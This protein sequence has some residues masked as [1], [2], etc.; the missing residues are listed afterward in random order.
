MNRDLLQGPTQNIPSF[1]TDIR[2]RASAVTKPRLQPGYPD[3]G[4]LYPSPRPLCLEL[5]LWSFLL[6]VHPYS[7]Y[8]AIEVSTPRAAA[9]ELWN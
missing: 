1:R 7:V 2:T 8:V 3:P 9:C 5:S 6:L 4:F